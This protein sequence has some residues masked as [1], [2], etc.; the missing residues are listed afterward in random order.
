MR[1]L[2]FWAFEDFVSAPNSSQ[3]LQYTGLESSHEVRLDF[4]DRDLWR[5]ISSE[6]LK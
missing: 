4:P 1:S 3:N 5:P 2:T 6:L